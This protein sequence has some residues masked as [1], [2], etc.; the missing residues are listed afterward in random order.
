MKPTESVLF[1]Q[2]LV[3]HV[4]VR[5]QWE[6]AEKT[7][8]DVQPR[9]HDPKQRTPDKG[10]KSSLVKSMKRDALSSHSNKMSHDA[11]SFPVSLLAAPIRNLKQV[12]N[13]A[14]LVP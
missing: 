12:H 6:K 2:L 3:V 11:L 13:R 7:S 14:P 5:L 10:L 8:K 9:S 4:F 1:K